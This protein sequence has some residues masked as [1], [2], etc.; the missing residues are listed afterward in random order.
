M[1]ANLF[2]LE[3]AT[4]VLAGAHVLLE[5]LCCACLDAA[6]IG[7]P[8]FAG[9]FTLVRSFV[10][11]VLVYL[12]FAGLKPALEGSQ[13]Q[14]AA[15]GGH[16]ASAA[17]ATPRVDVGD[18]PEASSFHQAMGSHVTK[19]EESTK[20]QKFQVFVKNPGG[21]TVVVRGFTGMDE[22]SLVVSQVESLTGVPGWS[23]WSSASGR[24]RFGAE[25]D[26]ARLLS[27]HDCAACGRVHETTS[28]TCARL[29]DVQQLHHG[30]V[31]AV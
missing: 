20:A 25:W 26:W 4:V 1:G 21:K 11:V 14:A 16:Y 15:A 17:N 13:Q 2:E 7:A 10:F 27:V 24:C 18:P 19:G 29:L 5:V 28:P 3:D 30:W 6:P 31:L 9:V 22:V 12:N 23:L 8:L